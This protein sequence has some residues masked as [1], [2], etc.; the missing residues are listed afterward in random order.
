MEFG[1]YLKKLR[2]E[3]GLTIRALEELSGVSNSYLSQIELG[4]RGAPSPDVL[5]KLA[6]PL[7][8]TIPKLMVK[9]G[10]ITYK[11]FQAASKGAKEYNEYFEL[12][13]TDVLG[14]EGTYDI[15]HLLEL[16][17]TI[18]YKGRKLTKPE[19]QK[20]LDIIRVLFQEQKG[21]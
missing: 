16:A 11:H 8:V 7:G 18:L 20:A 13:N 9:A 17:E 14:I 1:K 15:A 21:D 10:H 5:K 2:K 6:G 12:T 19:R 4:Q 3:R